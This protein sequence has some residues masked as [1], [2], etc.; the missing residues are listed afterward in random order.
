MYSSRD[1]SEKLLAKGD[2]KQRASD[3]KDAEFFRIRKE[4]EAA[5]QEKTRRLRELRLAHEATLPKAAKP[6]RA[7]SRAG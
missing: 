1:R 4:Q 3:A 7:R 6:A 5:N 2:A